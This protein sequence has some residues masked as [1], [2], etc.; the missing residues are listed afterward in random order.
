MERKPYFFDRSSL[1]TG[2]RFAPRQ[3][4]CFY[5][6]SPDKI[7]LFYLSKDTSNAVIAA[8]AGGA[9]GAVIHRAVKNREANKLNKKIADDIEELP[10][11]LR[12]KIPPFNK[13]V[14]ISKDTVSKIK[15][16]LVHL[17]INLKE[18]KWFRILVPLV[19]MK[20]AKSLKK[21]LKLTNW[22]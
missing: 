1:E 8:V 20:K 22:I 10:L 15:F 4:D 9:V 7:Y 11:E 17:I 21:Y 13:V 18:G 16:S 3:Y 12:K 14:V 6:I 19:K 5:L 2:R